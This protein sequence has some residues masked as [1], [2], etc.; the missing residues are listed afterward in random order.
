MIITATLITVA[1]IDNRII[2]RENDF[3]RL[4]AMRLAMKDEMF[5]N[6]SLNQTL[7]LKLSS[8]SSGGARKQT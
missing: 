4:N 7:F 8:I 5:T 3:C 2:N 6:K 1:V